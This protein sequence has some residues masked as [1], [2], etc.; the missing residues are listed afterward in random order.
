MK[1]KILLISLAL[2]MACTNSKS[3]IS[4]KEDIKSK[5]ILEGMWTLKSGKWSNDDGTFSVFPGDSLLEGLQAYIVYSKSH[6]NVVSEAPKMN[7]FRS[8]HVKYT[9]EEG[10]IKAQIILSN[11]EGSNGKESI[12]SLK[13]ENNLATFKK[14]TDI[15]V[16]KKVD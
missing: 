2:F 13:V 16:W 5:N 10:K 15:E 9:L 1:I 12:W 11:I 6:F 4:T 3:D 8:E 14:D 7:Y